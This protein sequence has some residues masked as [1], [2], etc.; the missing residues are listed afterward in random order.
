VDVYK[1]YGAEITIDQDH[2]VLAKVGMSAKLIGTTGTR[3]I[4]LQ[5]VAGVNFKDSSVL[6]NGWLQLVLGAEPAGEAS[7]SDPNTVL[8]RHKSRAHFAGLRDYLLG[9]VETNRAQGVDPATVP[10]DAPAQTRADRL[11]EMGHE[12]KAQREVAEEV[13]EE[14][15]AQRQERKE[16]AKAR[17]AKLEEDYWAK[18]RD[19][20]LAKARADGI[21]R[22]DILEAIA[23]MGSRFGAKRELKHLESYLQPEERV[24]KIASGTFNTELG[25]VVLTDSR[26]VFIFHGL[27][28]QVVEEFPLPTITAVSTKTGLSGGD[29]H[30]FTSATQAEISGMLSDD[31]RELVTEL[32]TDIARLR[33]PQPAAAPAPAVAPQP[34]AP[35][36]DPMDQLAK[37]GQLRDA[38]I[39]TDAEFEAKKTELLGRL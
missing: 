13:L 1:G 28:H 17:R 36:P 4:P 30:V 2:L 12:R 25:I 24:R 20:G 23:A 10:Y 15:R 3:R 33:S 19:K 37:L 22:P 6:M 39:L 11:V 27:T 29:L 26:L 8:F 38:G 18:K 9:V 5:A 14:A 31:V 34:A 35:A 32:R 21:T 7:A 16:E